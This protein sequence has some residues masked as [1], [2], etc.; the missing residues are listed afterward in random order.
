MYKL[1]QRDKPMGSQLERIS[2]VETKVESLAEKVD[3][4]KVSI[5]ETREA[6]TDKLDTMYEASCTQHAE[7]AKKLNEVE[8]FKD[9]WLYIIMGALA[10]LGWVAGHLD[11]LNKILN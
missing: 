3:D 9:K 8:K 1:K 6:L 4:L 11:L 2:V 10:V 5:G 7:L